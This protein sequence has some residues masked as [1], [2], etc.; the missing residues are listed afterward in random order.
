M[1]TTTCDLCSATAPKDKLTDCPPTSWH[2]VE[3][4]AG[5]SGQWDICPECLPKFKE[6]MT[7]GV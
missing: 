6:F 3:L 7:K 1:D 2:W 4:D 5:D